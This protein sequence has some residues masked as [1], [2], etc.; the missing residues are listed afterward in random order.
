M[1]VRKKEILGGPIYQ[2]CVLQDID[3]VLS[4]TILP[5]IKWGVVIR[6]DVSE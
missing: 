1:A 4:K 5:G 2:G 6:G 3:E